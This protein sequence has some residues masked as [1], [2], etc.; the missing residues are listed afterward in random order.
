M[1]LA[2]YMNDSIGNIFKEAV[3]S[4]RFN[5]KEL[6]FLSKAAKSQKQAAQKRIK[7]EACGATVPPFLIAS[8][9][10][11][12]NLHCAGCYARA[13]HA[14]TDKTSKDEM[15]PERWGQL[16][17]EARD[18]GVS[19]IILAGGEPLTRPDVL[20]AAAGIPEI[21]YPVFTNG[22]L[23]STDMLNRFDRCRNIIPV[24][25]IEGGHTQTDSRRG[26]GVFNTVK[27]AMEDMGRRGI[28]YGVS[29]T[30]TKDNLAAVTDSGFISGLKS[31]GC[32]LV[33]FV[34]YV[35]ADGNTKPALDE[36]DRKAM[37]KRLEGLKTSCQGIILLSFPGDEKAL[38]GCLAAGRGF[39][40]INAAGN[41]EP[42]PFSPYSDTSLK[43]GSLKDALN[44]ALFRKIR[45]SNL[46]SQ[47]HVGGCVLFAKKEEVE[48]MLR[49]K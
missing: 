43:T 31:I 16:F 49:Q 11:K 30:V 6:R 40:H 12:C 46:E 44:S 7:S 47:E 2:E 38:G 9:A 33:F 3:L 36:Q 24:L 25:S 37:E 21:I 10:T 19:F 17:M 41:A 26:K 18:L 45:E 8:V 32:R 4:S 27:K 34:E 35:P 22:T 1:E 28:F 20:D 29:V 14:C 13:N 15:L 42:C 39:F 23:F 48:G 5:A